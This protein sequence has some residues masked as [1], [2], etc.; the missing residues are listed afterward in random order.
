[1]TLAG[2]GLSVQGILRTLRPADERLQRIRM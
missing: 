2:R 1:M